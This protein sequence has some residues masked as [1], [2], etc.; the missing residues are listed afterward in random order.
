MCARMSRSTLETELETELENEIPLAW[1][2]Q[3]QGNPPYAWRPLEPGI[4]TAT[5]ALL[6]SDAA[7][8]EAVRGLC[9]LG[10]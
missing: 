9:S 7:A 4:N 1:P 2:C 8:R 6:A 10:D 3:F 5:R